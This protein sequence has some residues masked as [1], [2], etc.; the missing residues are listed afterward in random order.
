MYAYDPRDLG[1]T[2]IVLKSL[3]KYNVR[4]QYL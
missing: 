3:Q 2:L 4:N 1:L